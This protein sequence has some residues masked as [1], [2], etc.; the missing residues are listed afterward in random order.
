MVVSSNMSRIDND[1]LTS[2]QIH[3]NWGQTESF[4]WDQLPNQVPHCFQDAHNPKQM[5]LIH[6]DL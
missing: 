4:R 3:Q 2:H 1:L 5:D 6:E